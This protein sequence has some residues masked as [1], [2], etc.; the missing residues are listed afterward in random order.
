[1]AL[2]I[3]EY[4]AHIPHILSTDGGRY[5]SE[6]GLVQRFKGNS[7]ERRGLFH[8]IALLDLDLG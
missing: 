8:L 1:M 3:L 6:K 7:Q 4:N 2:G 5:V